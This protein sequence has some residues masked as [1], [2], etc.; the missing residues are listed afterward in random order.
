[1]NTAYYIFKTLIL[2]PSILILL[3]VLGMFVWR[4]SARTAFIIILGATLCLYLLSLPTVASLL[5]LPL[6]RYDALTVVKIKKSSAQAIVVLGGGYTYAPEYHGYTVAISTLMR[7]RYAAYLYHKTHLP[8]LVTGGGT[9]EPD[10]FEGP[11]MAKALQQE[12]NVPV[13]WIEGRSV[14]TEQNAKFSRALLQRANIKTIYLVTTAV[15]IPRAKWIFEKYGLHVI[16]APTDFVMKPGF[17]F[18]FL[19]KA[20]AFFQSQ[21]CLYE[22][23]GLVLYHLRYS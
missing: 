6:Q 22:Y 19:P 13:K 16:P 21:N 12:F 4:K 17:E 2:P 20:T 15:H 9:T 18:W 1:M 3:L 10:A 8:I 11:L 23:F 14:N 7:L 5:A